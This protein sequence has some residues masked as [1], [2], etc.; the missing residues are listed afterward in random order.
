MTALFSLTDTSA[1]PGTDV[2]HSVLT[3]RHTEHG[4]CSSG[5]KEAESP[6][7]QP[8]L[9]PGSQRTPHQTAAC[10]YLW[11]VLQGTDSFV[12][13]HSF[14]Q[15]DCVF[16]VTSALP[17]PLPGHQNHC[18]PPGRKS[19]DF[20][21]TYCVRKGLLNPNSPHVCIHPFI[22]FLSFFHCFLL[23]NRES[24]FSWLCTVWKCSWR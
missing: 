5:T 22:F 4:V 21:S 14:C 13:P 24:L 7:Q 18:T 3:C 17:L 11:V 6:G 20:W 1:A 23:Q 9:C 16:I 8:H 15:L 10:S 2:W 12:C 19:R